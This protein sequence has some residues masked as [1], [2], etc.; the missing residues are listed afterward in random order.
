MH[1]HTLQFSRSFH[2]V[3]WPD[4]TAVYH[5]DTSRFKAIINEKKYLMA[6]SLEVH[7]NTFAQLNSMNYWNAICQKFQDDIIVF[8]SIISF[9]FSWQ[10]AS[11]S[12]KAHFVP[13][14]LKLWLQAVLIIQIFFWRE[15]VIDLFLPKQ[16]QKRDVLWPDRLETWNADA[17]KDFVA[18]DFEHI[19]WHFV[20]RFFANE[21]ILSA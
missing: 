18:W 5:R 12:M 13:S 20:R 21:H 17:N 3:G 2:T 4:I 8:I 1:F 14:R 19:Q 11:C 7:K 15:I 6:G 16:Q 9:Y 10:H